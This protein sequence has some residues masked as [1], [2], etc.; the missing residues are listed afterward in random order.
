MSYTNTIK[1]RVIIFGKDLKIFSLILEKSGSLV[2]HSSG[3]AG[4]N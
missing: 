4:L 1:Y 2:I 3:A